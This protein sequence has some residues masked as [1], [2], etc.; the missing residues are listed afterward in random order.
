MQVTTIGP[1][2][3]KNVFQPH[4]ITENEEVVFNRPLRQA[5]LL[6][7]FAKI[8]QCLIGREA[9]SNAHHWARELTDLGHDVRLIP[10]MYVT[11]YVKRGKSDAIDAE[12]ICEAAMRPS[13]SWSALAD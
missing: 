5:Q 4:G 11:P 12:A 8:E 9:C 13:L 6:S 7:F 10:P 1:D 3:A 2:L